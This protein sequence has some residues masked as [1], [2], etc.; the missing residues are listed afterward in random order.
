MTYRVDQFFQTESIF[1]ILDHHLQPLAQRVKSYIKDTNQFLKIKKI[2]N[3]GNLSE[4]LILFVMEVVGLYSN[5][6]YGKLL[7]LSISFGN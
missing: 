7:R 6:P 5:V 3:I 2:K 1:S 4:G